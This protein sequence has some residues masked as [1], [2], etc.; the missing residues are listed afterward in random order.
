[1][2]WG[3]APSTKRGGWQMVWASSEYADVQVKIFQCQEYE[4]LA[5]ILLEIIKSMSRNIKH[6]GINIEGIEQAEKRMQEWIMQDAEKAVPNLKYNPKVDASDFDVIAKVDDM[7]NQDVFAGM[8]L[9]TRKEPFQPIESR[10]GYGL[11]AQTHNDKI[12]NSRNKPSLAFIYW[13]S[14][15]EYFG[16]CVFIQ[17]L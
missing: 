10:T 8:T 13:D 2:N 17:R 7:G 14:T 15:E 12:I 3:F 5:D 16:E 9:I 6:Y 11:A 4:V 1:M